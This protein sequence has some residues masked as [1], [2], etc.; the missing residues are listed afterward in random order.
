MNVPSAPLAK[1]RLIATV[2]STGK[3]RVALDAIPC[4]ATISP[5]S[6]RRLPI[7]WIRLIRIGPPRREERRER[8]V[9]GHASRPRDLRRTGCRIDDS[10]ES[11]LVARLD[12][13]DMRAPDE[14]RARDRDLQLAHGSCPSPECFT[15][16]LLTW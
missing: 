10:R 16:S 6:A 13:A 15:E 7:S 11:A 3:L 14:P 8:R 4:T 9:Q 12:Q 2:S 5:H 1:R